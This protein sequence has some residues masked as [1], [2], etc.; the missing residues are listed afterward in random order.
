[1]N[2]IVMGKPGSG[3]SEMVRH[4]TS[5][6]TARGFE[7]SLLSDRLG[8]EEAILM[9]TRDAPIAQDGSQTGPHSKLID[10]SR[11]AGQK[12]I[13]VLDGTL[14]NRVHEEMIASMRILQRKNGKKVV[15]AE[16]ATM[17]TPPL[18]GVPVAIAILFHF[19][20]IGLSPVFWLAKVTVIQVATIGY[21]AHGKVSY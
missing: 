17:P 4:L 21:L 18:V 8:L 11:P 19:P 15:L 9:D 3:K 12:Q 20:A 5:F 10:G 14:L 6:L 7:I 2:I 13:H 1:M 16:Y